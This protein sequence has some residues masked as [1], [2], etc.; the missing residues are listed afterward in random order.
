MYDLCDA[1]REWYLKFKEVLEGAGVHKR[2]FDYAIFDWHNNGKLDGILSCHV[3]NF[4]WGGTVNFMHKAVDVL[5][6]TFTI[7]SEE[8]E[9][10]KYLGPSVSQN[11]KVIIIQQIR[12]IDK[13][14]A[15]V[16]EKLRRKMRNAQL[17]DKKVQQLRAIAGQLNWT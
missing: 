12:Y 6:R 8:H 3:D 1:P 2:K 4:V 16:I 9:T 13:L 7:S 11:D 5:K 15:F 10:F 17:T 14:K